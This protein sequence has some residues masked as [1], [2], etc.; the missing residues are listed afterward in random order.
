MTVER[1]HW[2]QTIDPLLGFNR[3][4][5]WPSGHT[6]PDSFTI[7]YAE[8]IFAAF[9]YL[10]IGTAN[11]LKLRPSYQAY[12]L[13]TWMLA[14]STDFW[15]SVPRYVLTMF[16]LFLVLGKLSSKKSVNIAT[17]AVSSAGLFFF[18]WLFAS[19]A[20]AF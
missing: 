2:F 14:V 4:L 12:M 1:V 19:G 15:L 5:S 10:M 6:F 16:P 18:T 3:A 8:I 11:K 20:W 13:L 7:G 17:V 9:G